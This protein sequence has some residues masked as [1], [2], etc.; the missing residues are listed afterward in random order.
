MFLMAK[1]LID[2]IIISCDGTF[3]VICSTDDTLLLYTDK[4]VAKGKLFTTVLLE[5][6]LIFTL[7]VKQ[8]ETD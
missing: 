5:H 4:V 3:T 1:A 8:P 7:V 6:L 2:H